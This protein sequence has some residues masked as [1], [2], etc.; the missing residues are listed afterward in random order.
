MEQKTIIEL[1]NVTKH[2]SDKAGNFTI[3]ENVDVQIKEG[4][5]VAIV[6]PSGSGKSTLLSLF[7]GLD[8]PTQGE[9]IVD[10]VSLSKLNEQELADYRN[11]TIGIIFQSFEL[12]S[13]FTVQENIETPLLLSGVRNDNK[14]RDLIGRVGLSERSNNI[15]KTL[16]GGEK[17]R[18]AIARALVNNPKVILADEPTGSLDRETGKKVLDLLLEEI[19]EEK[20]TLIIITHDLSI[21]EKMDRVFEVKNKTLHEKR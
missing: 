15:P 11:K 19:G 13:P 4:E 3:L 9:I 5:K 16:S 8:M 18:V 7:A 2:F 10:G 12:I 6:G 1:N 21:A 20:K 14:V 17:Q